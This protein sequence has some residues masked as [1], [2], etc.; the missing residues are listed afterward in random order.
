MSTNPYQS[1]NTSQVPPETLPPQEE[2]TEKLPALAHL[3]CGWPLA[4]VA[5]GGAIGGALG[6]LAYG[7]NV[8]IYKSKLPSAA[9]VGLN[10]L[11]GASA[12]GIWAVVV[13]AIRRAWFGA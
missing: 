1:P 13:M 8:A 7:V 4:L 11:T 2:K 9:K 5:V 12:A 6:G 3:M 10:L